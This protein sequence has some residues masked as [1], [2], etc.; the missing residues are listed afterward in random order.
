[1]LGKGNLTLRI[2]LII[3][4]AVVIMTSILGTGY[5]LM[6]NA[7]QALL[8]EKQVKLF[9]FAK[10]LDV[11]LNTTFND[12]L[13]EKGFTEASREEKIRVLNSELKGITDFVAN[14]DPGIGIGYYSKELDAILTYGPSAELGNN[15]GQSISEN[16]QGRMVMLTGEAMVQ[17]APLVR[18]NIMNC[19]YPI[20]RNEQIIGYIWSNELVE[21]INLQIDKMQYRFRVTVFLGIIFSMIGAALIANSVISKVDIIKNGLK[22]IQKDLNY[23]IPP[24]EGE[25]GEISEA[26]NE[27][28]FTIAERKKFEEQIHRADRLAALGEITA[29]VAH[30]IR[31]PLTAIKGFVQL[32]EEDLPPGDSKLEYTRI[33][34]RE[35]D[36]M[37]KI[38]EELLYYARPY[39]S[40]RALI[41]INDTLD[42]TLMLVN[43][44]MIQPKIKVIKQ[45][46]HSLPSIPADEEQI[47]QVFLN[48]IINSIQAI[49]G[50]GEIL[51]ATDINETGEFVS[52][53]ISDTG[54]GI[55][56]ENLK[57]LFD[58]FFT[59]REKGT[60]LGL[61]VVYKIIEL[62]RGYIE[63]ESR[64]GQGAAFTVYLPIREGDSQIDAKEETHFN[65][66]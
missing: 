58:P 36:R 38:V 23:R 55:E 46:N 63:V 66:G 14:S 28:A 44:K 60:G 56:P 17:T 41:S 25:M 29:G 22:R 52:I 43:F 2:F 5:V 15:V 49:I 11:S 53:T 10:M 62:H 16:H 50:A 35:V 18:G 34:T 59:T 51:I 8:E 26:I 47:K 3:I 48:L 1:M 45:Y 65:C 32:I 31:N 13:S 9:A 39:E 12:I 27:M 30:E 19:M 6:Q 7:Q 40:C 42:G 33:V 57:K 64:L 21:D 37:N 20:I 54:D 61:P 4:I 24:M